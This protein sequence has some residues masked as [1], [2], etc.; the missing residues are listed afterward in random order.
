MK[1]VY[2]FSKLINPNVKVKARFGFELADYDVTFSMLVTTPYIP[3][4]FSPLYISLS[5]FLSIYIYIYI[6]NHK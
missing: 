6:Y 2:T 4:F 3:S 5:L 1:W